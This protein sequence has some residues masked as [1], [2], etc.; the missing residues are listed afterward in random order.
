VGYRPVYEYMTVHYVYAVPRA[1]LAASMMV[2]AFFALGLGLI[3]NST[4]LRL[5][6]LEKLIWKR[7]AKGGD[8]ALAE[9]CPDLP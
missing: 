9:R 7:P 1:I 5:L 3:L 4:N 8:A 6:E 2:L